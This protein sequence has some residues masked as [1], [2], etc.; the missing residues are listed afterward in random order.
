VRFDFRKPTSL[1]FTSMFAA[2]LADQFLLFVVPLVVYQTT[3]SVSLSGLAYAAET[4]PR[5]LFY[6]VCGVLSDRYS[7]LRL[8]QL[9]QIGR[10]VICVL[11]LIGFAL[12]DGLGW[13]VGISAIC[14][15]LT[16]QGFMAREVL[17]PQ[18]FAR[19]RF[20][21]IQSVSQS[22]NQASIV[23]GP[24][25]A[26]TLFAISNWQTV[27]VVAAVLFAIAELSMMIWRHFN[28][29]PIAATDEN[30]SWIAPFK[31]AFS[32]LISLP[33]L[34]R[35]IALTASVNLVF[36]ITLAT[37]AAMVTGL[38]GQSEEHYALLQTVGAAFT[39]IVL[40]LVGASRL[41]V[42]RI[43]LISFAGV[44]LGGVL[45]AIS[46]GYWLYMVGFAVV[47]G[48]D[49]MFN[50][51]IRTV[52]Q[53]I[54]PARDYGKTTGVIILFNNMTQPIAG[55]LVGLTG[56]LAQTSWLILVLSLVMLVS[57][58]VLSLPRF[59]VRAAE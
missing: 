11:G 13:V 24:L 39:I 57:G 42:G 54:I 18:I 9:S 46:P 32:H 41:S 21:K 56:S 49:G 6:P 55:L 15:L 36:G 31:T 16:T 40:M 25:L 35:V 19:A 33:G 23:L 28:Q 51:Y 58:L 53:K 2:R 1:F 14:G 43:G 48:F 8:M 27:V 3:Q 38:H 45:T 59:N 30:P 29:T 12:F 5:V 17:L 7:P 47:L 26:A 52:R 50:I 22:V 20:E 37:S 44:F 10:A 4:L 34:K